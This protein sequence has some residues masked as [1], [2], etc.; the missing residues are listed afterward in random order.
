[1]DRTASLRAAYGH[2]TSP[3]LVQG[4]EDSRRVPGG[5]VVF[6]SCCKLYSSAL[7]CPERPLEVLYHKL[8]RIPT[9][10]SVRQA[11]VRV[12]ESC[13]A[14]RVAQWSQVE[15]WGVAGGTRVPL[16]LHRAG[17][18]L[19]ECSAG[20]VSQITCFEE[21]RDLRKS[22]N[23][24]EYMLGMCQEQFISK[25]TFRRSY[26]PNMKDFHKKTKNICP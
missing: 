19:P 23:E 17:Q 7:R 15:S 22:R 2:H 4:V 3:L 11:T 14:T 25:S 1:M 16:C 5:T 9:F 6:P 24:Q 8:A 10:L 20:F 26:K 13:T 18:R 12:Y 21:L